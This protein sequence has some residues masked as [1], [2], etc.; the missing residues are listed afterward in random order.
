MSKAFHH[1]QHAGFTMIEVIATLVILAVVSAVVISRGTGTAATDLQVEVDTLK[2]KL[3]YAQYL[4]MNDI[5]PVKWGVQMNGTSYTLVKNTSGDGVTFTQ[6]YNLPNESSAAHSIAPFSATSVNILFDEWGIPY[7]A[8][9]KL[10][11]AAVITVNPGNQT[12]TITPETGFI[13]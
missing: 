7:N 9:A 5:S 2:G 10:A 11:A 3:R 1:K 8:A 4:A 6:P 13:P 12:V